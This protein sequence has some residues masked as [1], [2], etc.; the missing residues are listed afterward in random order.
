MEPFS[1]IGAAVGL[2]D[3][4]VRLVTCVRQ[5]QKESK[6]IQQE[7]QDLD[8]EI[9]D[10]KALCATLDGVVG[11]APSRGASSAALP[12][13]DGK[14]TAVSSELWARMTVTVKSCRSTLDDMEELVVQIYG[15]VLNDKTLRGRISGKV[16]NLKTVRRKHGCKDDLQN[17]R[18]K[19]KT[20]I[21]TLQLLFGAVSR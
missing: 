10:L 19:L 1:T 21:S 17:A 12:L 14:E 18:K 4:C 13:P 6:S 20:N 7:L 11:P 15:D 9:E 5:V 16:D 3:V 8:T 2:V